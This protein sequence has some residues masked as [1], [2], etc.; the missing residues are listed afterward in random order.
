MVLARVAALERVAG[1]LGL[2]ARI[3]GVCGHFLTSHMVPVYRAS[4]CVGCCHDCNDEA[5][6][7]TEPAVLEHDG[8]GQQTTDPR[9]IT[10]ECC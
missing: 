1:M 6:A 2:M 5:P 3:C 4:S 10:D 9:R 8:L 7:T